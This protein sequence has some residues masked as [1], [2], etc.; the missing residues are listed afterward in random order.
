[1]QLISDR[2]ST[3]LIVIHHTQH[4]ARSSPT[5]DQLVQQHMLTHMA[6]PRGSK[7]G[8]H[9]YIDE[10][11]TTWRGRHIDEPSLMVQGANHRSVSV[12]L[13]CVLDGADSYTMEAFTESQLEMLEVLLRGLM[14]KY[15][16]ARIID[17]HT[18]NPR[19]TSVAIDVDSW[20]EAKGIGRPP[21]AT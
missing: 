1:M 18:I 11:G 4:T 12:L 20:L 15:P 9:Y 16:V 17:H 10:S 2:P 21:W 7:V 14:H 3:E 19:R 8:F 13:S 6:T 5:L